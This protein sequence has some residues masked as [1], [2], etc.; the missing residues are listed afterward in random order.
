MTARVGWVVGAGCFPAALRLLR[1]SPRLWWWCVLPVVVNIAT[2]VL[3]VAVFL[4]NL[5]AVTEALRAWLEAADPAAWYQWLWVGPLR[6][7]SWMLRWVLIGLLAVAVYVL[8]TL[9][10]GILASPFLDVLSQRVEAI[11]T[12]R[13]R[14]ETE[15]GLRG[16]LAGGL[17]AALEEA[18]RT[19]LFVAIQGGLCLLGLL[20]GLQLPAALGALGVTVLFLSLDYSGYL[21]DRRGVPFR[22]RRRWVWQHRRA[23][24]GF[25]TTAFLTFLVPGLN[26]LCLPLLVTAGTL[27]ALELGVPQVPS[28]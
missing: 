8:F 14:D 12:G 22:V 25:G 24:L 17:R 1:A 7:L 9:V 3:A 6:L 19:F 28:G 13:V 26:F 10:G 23:M 18:K 11:R 16:A 2:F 27:L 20:P 4:A 5:D 15:P 21:L